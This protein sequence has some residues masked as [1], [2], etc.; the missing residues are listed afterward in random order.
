MSSFAHALLRLAVVGSV[1]G[2]RRGSRKSNATKLT[3][4][5]QA[6]PDVNTQPNFDIEAYISTR[7][8]AQEQAVTRYLPANANNC[9]TAK[10]TMS[11]KKSFW[12]YSVKVQNN[13]KFDDGTPRGGELCAYSADKSDAAKLAVAPCFLPKL[14]AGPYWVLSFN[15]DKG[16]ALISGG[17]PKVQ[18]TN[19]CRTGKGRNNAGLWIFTREV[20]PAAGLVDEV[21]AIAAQ[22]FDLSVLNKV[23]HTGCTGVGY[24]SD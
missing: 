7:W 21:R 15:Q 1:G 4:T 19:G 24:G 11:A 5:A 23:N 12:R 3:A 13:A 16:Y 8:Y 14:W 6:C 9:V 17:Q 22:W 10:Y 2:L 20:F 18:G